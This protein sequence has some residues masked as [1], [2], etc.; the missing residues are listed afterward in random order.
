VLEPAPGDIRVLVVDDHPVVRQGLRSFL[1]S[2]EGIEV[3]GEAADGEAALGELRRLRPD[4]VLMDLV[5]PGAGG[6]AAIRRITAEHPEVRTLVLTSFSSE[7]D[8]IPAV[9][10]GAVGYL[11]K[12]VAPVELEA[13]VRAAFRREATLSPEVMTRVMAEVARG[14]ATTAELDGLTPREIDVLRLLAAGRSNRALATELYVSERT[15]KAHV[16]NILAKLHVTDRT[17]AA[18]WAVRHGLGPST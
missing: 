13:A 11:L 1:S 4:V 12:D 5:M 7:G 3:V 2:R 6:V 18:L 17:Q 15:V 10:A 9:A 8:V 16:S 14:S